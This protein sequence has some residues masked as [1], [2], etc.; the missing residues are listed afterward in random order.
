M[1]FV[2]LIGARPVCAQVFCDHWCIS[3]PTLDRYVREI[4]NGRREATDGLRDGSSTSLPRDAKKTRFVV[5]WFLQYAKEI[6][7]KLPDCDIVLLP[8]AM[9]RDMHAEFRNDML[10]AGETEEDICKVDHFRTT[11]KTSTEL[12]HMQITKFKRNFAKCALCVKFTSDVN[13]ALKSHDTAALQTAKRLRFEHYMLARSDKLHYWEQRWNSRAKCPL[14]LTLIIDKM[15]SAKNHV[16]WFSN[17]RKPKDIEPLLRDVIK[18]HVTG[19]IIH[20]NPD[21][22]Y[23]FWSLPYMPGNANLNIECMRRALVHY[24]RG[25]TFRPQLYIQFDGASDNRCFAMICLCG[26]LVDRGYVSKVC[27]TDPQHH[28]R[29]FT[30]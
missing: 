24:L 28:A 2:Y 22:R 29:R 13:A 11:F 17:G 18:L 21:A 1:R 14:K 3:K 12:A 6:T 8:R 27:P 4:K 9:W 23:V 25:R 26:W 5:T 10:A 19:V 20:G 15:D 30:P 16:P 7:E